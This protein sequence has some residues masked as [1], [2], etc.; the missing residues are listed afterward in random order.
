MEHCCILVHT[1]K[2]CAASQLA[3][4]LAAWLHWYG[5]LDL[6]TAI[7]VCMAM[8]L[9]SFEACASYLVEIPA[10]WTETG[11]WSQ[12]GAIGVPV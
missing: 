6:H 12:A 7:Q 10:Q 5:R 3:T 8:P 9:V 1:A 11:L 2:A 4:V